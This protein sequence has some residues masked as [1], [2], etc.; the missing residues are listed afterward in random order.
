MSILPQSN[1][2]VNS[3]QENFVKTVKSGDKWTRSK[4]AS[5]KMAARL[6]NAGLRERA[7]RMWQCGDYLAIQRTPD[8]ELKA[9]APQLCRDRLCPMCSWRL[10]RRRF[11]EMMAVF[12]SLSAEII[13]KDYKA[14]MLTLTIRNM[15]LS[16]LRA[17]IDAM[18]TAWHN[19]IRR[20]LFRDCV[21]WARSLEITY[22]AKADT[23]HPHMHIILIW[24]RYDE[25]EQ[26]GEIIKEAW[27]RAA[28]LNYMPQTDIRPVYSRD[29]GKDTSKTAVIKAALEAFKYAVKPDAL[30]NVPQ[31]ELLEFALAIKGVRFV[32][33]G[34]AIKAARQ[35]LGFTGDDVAEPLDVKGVLPENTIVALL[36][37]NGSDY[38]KAVLSE[39]NWKLTSSQLACAIAAEGVEE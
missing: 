20:E 22:N 38:A 35:A 6:Y 29:D 31:S 1:E 28:E 18:A 10:A 17:S 7:A 3:L 24:K 23:Y 19:M 13:E 34:K 30:A 25:S 14:T 16:D 11:A 32:S 36:A 37:W 15:P 4:A 9:D 39:G 33:Y 8:G 2:V 21:G 12:N 26:M 5:R 27:K